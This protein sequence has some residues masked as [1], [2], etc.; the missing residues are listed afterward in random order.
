MDKEEADRETLECA[1]YGEEDDLRSL[2]VSHGA[3]ANYADESGT[4]AMH[5]A[6]ANGEVG[7]MKILKEFGSNHT[8]NLQGNFP[9]HW[10]ALNAQEAALQFLFQSYDIDVLSK[11]SNGRSTLSEAF[12][13]QKTEIIEICLSHPSASE[14]NL[15]KTDADTRITVDGD[16]A[17]KHAVVHEMDFGSCVSSATGKRSR[18]NRR[19]LKIRELPITRAD[20]PFGS[21]TAPE[22]D[23][24]GKLH[25]LLT[26]SKNLVLTVLF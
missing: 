4:T 5:R 23:T 13:T 15:L 20:S 9:I 18:E 8:Q 19:I 11:N 3:D 14:E 10:A 22:D 17:D 24:T 6:A 7:C 21:D 12:Q 26:G 16:D 2:F 25:N 1:R